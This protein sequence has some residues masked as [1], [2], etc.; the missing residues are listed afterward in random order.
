M[1]DEQDFDSDLGPRLADEL[2]CRLE[3]QV[4]RAAPFFRER[5]VARQ[6]P[7]LERRR[8]RR[9]ALAAVAAA[10]AAGGAAVAFWHIGRDQQRPVDGGRQHDVA[11]VNHHPAPRA[12]V[13]AAGKLPGAIEAKRDAPSITP[14]GG[15]ARPAHKSAAASAPPLLVIGRSLR[16]R[17]FVEGTL[18]VGRTPMRKVRRQWLERVEWFDPQHGARLQRIVPREEIVFLPLTIN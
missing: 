3:P 1:D 10:L 11:A 5:C 9:P 17:T 18:L 2:R 15:V 4:G 7:S 8:L 12:D 13:A 6:A 14:D 16:G